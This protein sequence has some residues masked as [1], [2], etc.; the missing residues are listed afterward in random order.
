MWQICSEG[1]LVEASKVSKFFALHLLMLVIPTSITICERGFSEQN[2][3]RSAFQSCRHLNTLDTW[4]RVSPCGFSVDDTDWQTA[5]LESRN[6]R[7]CRIL[8]IDLT[9]LGV[10]CL[11]LSL[12]FIN[13]K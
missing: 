11:E 10:T 13:H 2:I 3:A 7:D 4:M 12:E 1:V 5:L 9:S 6:M 8:V